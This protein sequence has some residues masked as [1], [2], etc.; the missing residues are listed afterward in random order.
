MLNNMQ[1]PDEPKKPAGLRGPEFEGVEN[2]L[3]PAIR[4][5]LRAALRDAIF[6]AFKLIASDLMSRLQG[7]GQLPAGAFDQAGKAE[8]PPTLGGERSTG[9]FP[10]P[11]G[12]VN[13]THIPVNVP[14][15]EE[16]QP[17]YGAARKLYF[18]P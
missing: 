2:I 5:E 8:N 6:D 16:K 4:A 9:T 15:P 7:N 14:T 11:H 18:V 3:N 13:L 1:L 17:R 12:D 10:H